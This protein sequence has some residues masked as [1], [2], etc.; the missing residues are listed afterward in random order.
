MHVVEKTLSFII[1]G[2]NEVGGVYVWDSILAL[3]SRQAIHVLGGPRLES[4]SVVELE[5]KNTS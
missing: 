1:L 5:E 4:M 3:M 2:A